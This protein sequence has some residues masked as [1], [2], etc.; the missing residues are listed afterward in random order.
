[1]TS[2]SNRATL[3]PELV[4][5]D[6]E[7]APWARERLEEPGVPPTRADPAPAPPV[8]AAPK[9]GADEARSAFDTKLTQPIRRRRR[10]LIA[11][12][13]GVAVVAAAV[14]V[15]DSD[16]PGVSIPG[17]GRPAPALE[18]ESASPS[19]PHAEA[20]PPAPAGPASKR[21]ATIAMPRR[22]A[23]APRA[24]ASGYYVE[25]FRGQMLVF[26][27]T[28]SRPEIVIPRRWRL[29]GRTQRLEPGSYR[30]YVW[31]HVGGRREGKATVQ[32]KLVLPTR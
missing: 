21:T 28:T 11:A 5:V 26:R 12:V 17:G 27:A 2:G 30:W 1:V 31:A 23:W 25:L 22:F 3:S 6:P 8:P 7:L 29:N 18:H 10:F 14:L 24:G 20:P 19:A 15:V 4:L 13:M 9:V 16:A 32:A